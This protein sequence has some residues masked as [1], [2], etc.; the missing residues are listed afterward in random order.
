VGVARPVTSSSAVESNGERH[1]RQAIHDEAL[2]A[3]GQILLD[4]VDEIVPRHTE[5]LKTDRHFSRIE[6]MTDVQIADHEATFLADLDR[7]LTVMTHFL[8]QSERVSL[9]SFRHT[10]TVDA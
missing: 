5:A 7:A 8:T 9:Q 4:S 1:G 2:A 10:P 6:M 3:V